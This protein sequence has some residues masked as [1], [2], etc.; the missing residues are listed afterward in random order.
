[1]P[2]PYSSGHVITDS[3]DDRAHGYVT[4]FPKG[5]TLRIINRRGQLRCP[6]YPGRANWQ[7]TRDG[8]K[9]HILGVAK[10]SS[11]TDEKKKSHHRALVRN[12]GWLPPLSSAATEEEESG[13][14]DD[15]WI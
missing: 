11:N 2:F 3:E 15:G 4:P 7:W 9:N 5:H 13:E 8:T 12:E 10:E 14:D 1:L 6:I